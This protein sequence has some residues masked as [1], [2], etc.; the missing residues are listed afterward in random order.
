MT[1]WTIPRGVA[2]GL[3]NRKRL[4]VRKTPQPQVAQAVRRQTVLE[5][6]SY[7]ANTLPPIRDLNPMAKNHAV[8]DIAFPEMLHSA[9]I[10]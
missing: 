10:S 1:P 8:A 6:E 9:Y 3:G 5:I 7:M 4:Q 2:L